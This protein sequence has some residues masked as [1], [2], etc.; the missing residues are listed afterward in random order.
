MFI[1]TYYLSTSK[2]IY[3]YSYIIQ[4]LLYALKGLVIRY[5]QKYKILK[6]GYISNAE[7]RERIKNNLTDMSLRSWD[8]EVWNVSGYG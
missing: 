5:K 1:R 7:I 6:R 2:Q 8:K 4:I 3:I